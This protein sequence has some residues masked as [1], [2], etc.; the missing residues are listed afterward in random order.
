MRPFIHGKDALGS[1]FP[2]QSG[3]RWAARNRGAL[4]AR[5]RPKTRS[6]RVSRGG[7]EWERTAFDRLRGAYSSQSNAYSKS[8]ESSLRR[9]RPCGWHLDRDNHR[10]RTGP[11]GTRPSEIPRRLGS[12]EGTVAR[13][14]R[15]FPT[16][17]SLRVLVSLRLNRAA[18]RDHMLRL[19]AEPVTPTTAARL[20]FGCARLVECRIRR[21]RRG[22]SA[23]DGPTLLREPPS[24]Y[25]R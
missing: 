6:L 2:A 13:R 14:A 19:I 23:L 17:C 20:R 18:I 16:A 12:F 7:S 15:G 11:R 5:S 9:G 1:I 24:R 25:S 4:A 10:H 21:Q 22:L 3:Q 8:L